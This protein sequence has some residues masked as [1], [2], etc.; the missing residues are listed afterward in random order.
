MATASTAVHRRRAVVTDYAA[1]EAAHMVQSE[2]EAH[3]IVVETLHRFVDPSAAVTQ[4]RG[5]RGCFVYESRIPKSR[6]SRVDTF[7]S[8]VR[9]RLGL[10]ATCD[11][12]VEGSGFL[13]QISVPDT[14]TPTTP[15]LNRVLTV[16]LILL[17]LYAAYLLLWKGGSL[18]V[19]TGHIATFL[20][21]HLPLL[22]G[23]GNNEERAE[24]PIDYVI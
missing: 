5:H 14:F 16:A 19:T 17:A 1:E 23:F 10:D 2:A 11:L 6:F 13:V 8:E 18:A 22:H 20:R 3:R 24:P 9:R 4:A 15:V 7:T 12:S 21:R